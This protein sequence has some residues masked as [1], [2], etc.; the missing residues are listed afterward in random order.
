MRNA[1]EKTQSGPAQCDA[2][3][4]LEK[5]SISARFIESI[6]QIPAFIF[7]GGINTL[8]LILAVHGNASTDL[9]P[10]CTAAFQPAPR[11]TRTV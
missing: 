4:Q 10:L 1:D 11:R 2:L 5:A 9:R 8:S 3:L 6:L 7:L